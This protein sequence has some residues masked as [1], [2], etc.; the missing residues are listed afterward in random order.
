MR[1]RTSGGVAGVGPSLVR[2][3]RPYADPGGERARGAEPRDESI[4]RCRIDLA[5]GEA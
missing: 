2:R 4:T 3:G 5:K 1:S